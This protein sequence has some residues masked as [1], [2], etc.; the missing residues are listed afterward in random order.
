[1]PSLTTLLRVGGALH[2]AVLTASAMVP[3]VL[4]WRAEL[5]RLSPF[6]RRHIWV[7]GAFVVLTIAGFGVLTLVH[8]NELASGTPLARSF[9]G[10]V[11]FFWLARLGVQALVFDAAPLLATALRKLGYHFLTAVF[12]YFTLV[13]GWAALA[14]N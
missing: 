10:F 5:G 12:T 13:Y 8:A 6:S 2:F 1:M 9:C 4:E 7:L 14:T 3:R 11:A